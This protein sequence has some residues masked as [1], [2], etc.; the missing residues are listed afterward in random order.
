MPCSDEIV[1]VLLFV[2]PHSDTLWGMVGRNVDQTT[3]QHQRR[4]LEQVRVC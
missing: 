2:F 3:V 4:K 1:A